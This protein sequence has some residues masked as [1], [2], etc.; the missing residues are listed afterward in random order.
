MIKTSQALIGTAALI[1]G[2]ATVAALALPSGA[3]ASKAGYT[4]E[5]LPAHVHSAHAALPTI[6]LTVR[7]WKFTRAA[8]NVASGPVQVVVHNTGR[9]SH[10]IG[11]LRTAAKAGKLPLVNGRPSAAGLVRRI[12][13]KPGATA[14]FKAVVKDGHYALICMLPTHYSHGMSADV[15]VKT[16]AAVAPVAAAGPQTSTVEL[17]ANGPMSFNKKTLN[18]VEG[19]VTVAMTNSSPLPHSV[20]IK[21]NGVD[22]KGAVVDNGQVSKATAKLAPGTYT[23][24]CTVPGHSTAGMTG[25]LKVR[26]A[27]K[28]NDPAPADELSVPPTAGASTTAPPAPVVGVP[29]TPGG[30]TL[31]KLTTSASVAFSTT[32]MQA[33]AGVVT[34]E[35]TNGVGVDHGIGLRGP[36]VNQ[37]GALVGQGGVSTVTATLAPGTYTFF[38]I[39]GSHENAGMSG[40]LTV[41]APAGSGTGATPAPA[42]PGLNVST[43]SDTSFDVTSLTATAGQVTIS[44]K[45]TTSRPQNIA[46]GSDGV[47]AAGPI[48]GS[49]QVSTLTVTL[50]PGKYTYYSAVGDSHLKGTL[51]VTAG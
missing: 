41:T 49:G 50:K 22:V 20:G 47:N 37:L 6:H 4:S 25:T 18:A 31:L 24:Y 36:G 14:A 40:T 34:I 35:F 26:P 43:A 11:L 51:T 19:T 29:A 39:V 17:T 8:G 23:F 27:A 16:S 9:K 42:A 21:G 38:C 1:A 2:A 10:V 12:V 45:N 30:P 46:L 3:E 5:L 15:S 28:A 32:Q 13:I 44:L 33:Q 7:E 48:V